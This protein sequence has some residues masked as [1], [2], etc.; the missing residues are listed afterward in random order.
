MH[1]RVLLADIELLNA[2]EQVYSSEFLRTGRLTMAF[3]GSPD[4]LSLTADSGR[5]GPV[6]PREAVQ[7]SV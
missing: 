5:S 2:F 3:E 6:I 7:G 4:L 1:S